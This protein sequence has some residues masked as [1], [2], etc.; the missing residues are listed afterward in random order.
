[1]FWKRVFGKYNYQRKTASLNNRMKIFFPN[2]TFEL[3]WNKCVCSKFLYVRKSVELGRRLWFRDCLN[4]QNYCLQNRFYRTKTIDR[5]LFLSHYLI[6]CVHFFTHLMLRLIRIQFI[7]NVLARSL[8]IIWLRYLIVHQQRNACQNG[9]IQW[10]NA[11]IQVSQNCKHTVS[12]DRLI[13]KD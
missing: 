1:M 2:L 8:K 13:Q 7:L 9:H 6:F 11:A 5:M 12:F 10:F 3:L 4:D